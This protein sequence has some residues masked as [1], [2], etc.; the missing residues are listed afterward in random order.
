MS[1]LPAVAVTT[2]TRRM[3]VWLVAVLC[4]L[5]AAVQAATG[6]EHFQAGVTAFRAG[7][8]LYALSRFEQARRAGY[9][10]PVLD[11]NVGVSHYKLGDYRQARP[12][13]ERATRSPELRGVAYYNLGL[14]ALRLDET[15]QALSRFEQARAVATDESLKALAERQI[16]SLESRPRDPPREWLA[17][18]AV[19]LG[20]DD[21]IVDPVTETGQVLEDGLVELLALVSGPVA[22]TL[23]NGVR[24]DGSLYAVHYR[25][26]DE[27]DMTVLRAGVAG[28]RVLGDWQGELAGHYEASTLGGD[29]YLHTAQLTL[30]GARR[31]AE[32]ARLRL[33]YRYAR[34]DADPFYQELDGWRQQFDVQNRW[35]RDG[36]N[37]VLVYQLEINDRADLWQGTTSTSYSPTRHQLRIGGE[38][39]LPWKW[40]GGAELGVRTSRY[41]DPNRMS[42]SRPV[43]RE[44]GQLLFRLRAR[45]PLAHGWE[46][47]LEYGHTLNESN[48]DLYDYRRNLVLLGV[49]G[50]W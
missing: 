29:D 22:G 1:S 42:G 21:N 25:E 23:R 9:D 39:G 7:D 24:V 13:L 48:I 40:I 33:R 31:W 10:S 5:A 41:A 37:L 16:A 34:I 35:G 36:H 27:Y 11:Y 50:L 47:V 46:F 49:N 4:L 15:Q 18:L 32:S 45:R 3:R 26:Y 2:V 43:T 17:N 44:D 14:T 8:Y 6:E 28:L 19:N 30:A 38:T 12:A 20:Y